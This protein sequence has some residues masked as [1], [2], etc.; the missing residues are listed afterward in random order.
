MNRAVRRKAGN[1]QHVATYN[2]T[3]EGL[4]EEVR[5]RVKEQYKELRNEIVRDVVNK[6]FATF[7]VSL[8]DLYGFGPYRINKL[9][10]KS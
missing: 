9:L 10:Q 5:K 6:T 2:F 1:K 4:D 8:H 3:K 7:C